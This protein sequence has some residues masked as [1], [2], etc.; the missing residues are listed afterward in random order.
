MDRPAKPEEKSHRGCESHHRLNLNKKGRKMEKLVFLREYYENDESS[1]KA[2]RVYK[3]G[4]TP[5][6]DFLVNGVVV[7]TKEYPDI[8]IDI[9]ENL[10]EDYIRNV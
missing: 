6:I 2:S 4:E 5:Y 1:G 8:P 10:A 7:S 3:V 9:V